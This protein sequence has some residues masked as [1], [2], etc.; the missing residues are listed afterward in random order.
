MSQA[1]SEPLKRVHQ[2]EKS[3]KRGTEMAVSISVYRH[4]E[5]VVAEEELL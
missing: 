1:A 4:K 2:K 5:D 3:A